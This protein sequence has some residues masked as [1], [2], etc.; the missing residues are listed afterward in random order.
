MTPALLLSTALL[1]SACFTA[2]NVAASAMSWLVAGLLPASRTRVRTGT[3]VVI[4]LFPAAASLLITLVLFVPAHWIT[5]TRDAKESFGATIYLLGFAGVFLMA[6]ACRRAAALASA[7][8]RLRA[9]EQASAILPQVRQADGVPGLALAGLFRTRILIGRQVAAAL[10]AAELEVAIA[11]E[12]AH[13]AAVDNLKRWAF[14]CAPDLFGVSGRARRL[15]R[16]WHAAAESVADARAVGG[17]PRRA[18]DLASALVKVARFTIDPQETARPAW[19][20]FNDPLLLKRRVEDLV[21]AVP[22]A[23]PSR[24]GRAAAVAACIVTAVALLVPSA[25]GTIHALT[26]AAVS[27]L[28]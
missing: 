9:G 14:H 1:A 22:D 17:S 4:R 18:V 24:P 19:S 15:E 13:G 23:A 16:E 20:T 2:V 28:P 6:R 11:H 21:S 3:L 26:E 10:T 12:L 8:R 7:D 25:A 5:E 27:W